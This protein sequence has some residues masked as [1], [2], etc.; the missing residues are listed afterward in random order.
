VQPDVIVVAGSRA[1]DDAVARWAYR[2]RTAAGRLPLALFHRDVHAVGPESRA[3][4]LSPQASTAQEELLAL[5]EPRA[6]AR[7]G[8]A[9]A[10]RNGARA[11]RATASRNG[12]PSQVRGVQ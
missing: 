6:A 8:T 1:D 10:S 11:S 2:L 5:V 12:V 7:R 3:R 9:A 4:I